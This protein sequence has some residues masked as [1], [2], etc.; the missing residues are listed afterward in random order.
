[1]WVAHF[2]RNATRIT[3]AA[4]PSASSSEASVWIWIWIYAPAVTLLKNGSWNALF[5]G[6]PKATDSQHTM[7]NFLTHP[8]K[9]WTKP[10]CAVPMDSSQTISMLTSL[11]RTATMVP[12]Q[13]RNTYIS[14]PVCLKA[15]H[16][17]ALICVFTWYSH[18]YS[19]KCRWVCYP[20]AESVHGS[21]TVRMAAPAVGVATTVQ[22]PQHYLRSWHLTAEAAVG[23]SCQ[24]GQSCQDEKCSPVHC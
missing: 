14:T 1:M 21:Y 23:Q 15:W 3:K 5:S 2:L 18:F 20:I 17:N 12:L 13:H 7:T 10:A 16:T 19:C 22:L 8:S 9:H 6:T 4:A 11:Q 24:A